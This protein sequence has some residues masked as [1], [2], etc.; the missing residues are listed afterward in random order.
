MKHA[1]LQNER[2]SHKHATSTLLSSRLIKIA[3]YSAILLGLSIV[4]V[5]FYG[6]FKPSDV[7]LNLLITRFITI[8][9]IMT[10]HNNVFIDT[11][12]QTFGDF[13]SVMMLFMILA[14]VIHSLKF[15]L[16]ESVQLFQLI[17]IPFILFECLQLLG[18]GNF[19]IRDLFAYALGYQL[20]FVMVNRIENTTFKSMFELGFAFIA[21]GKKGSNHG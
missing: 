8:T 13:L 15:P 21:S 2:P 20:G 10:E 3:I 7:I 19:Y 16:Q 11:F 6:L 14:I 1:R 12:I 18:I 4:S 9:P 17:I 5:V